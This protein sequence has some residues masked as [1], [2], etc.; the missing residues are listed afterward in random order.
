MN[1]TTDPKPDEMTR[2]CI[3]A[4]CGGVVDV[5]IDETVPYIHELLYAGKWR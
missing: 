2:G 5:A 4:I 3:A 1:I